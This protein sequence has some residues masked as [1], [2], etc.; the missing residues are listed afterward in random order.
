MGQRVI[1]NVKTLEL[2]VHNAI[3]CLRD[4]L[5]Q[6]QRQQAYQNG[7]VDHLGGVICPAVSSVEIRYDFSSCLRIFYGRFS[8]ILQIK[9]GSTPRVDNRL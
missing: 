2:R 4:P 7:V 6:I 3:L 8:L 9:Y 5:H 1:S